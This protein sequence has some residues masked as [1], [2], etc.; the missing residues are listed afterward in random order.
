MGESALLAETH[1]DRLKPSTAQGFD[2]LQ[3]LMRHG[4]APDPRPNGSSGGLLLR[5]EFAPDL[6]LRPDGSV[7]VPVG[8]ALK[9]RPVPATAP[10]KRKRRW[11]RSFFILVGLA[12]YTMFALA[13]L[14]AVMESL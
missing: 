6:I 10:P 2:R 3:E 7:D 11:L 14:V 1:D 4:Y 5:H 12:M 8:Q 9:M 13:I